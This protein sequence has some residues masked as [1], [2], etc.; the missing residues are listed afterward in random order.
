MQAA[1]RKTFTTDT[2]IQCLDKKSRQRIYVRHGGIGEGWERRGG[3]NRG[4]KGKALGLEIIERKLYFYPTSLKVALT[5]CYKHTTIWSSWRE[6]LVCALPDLY[7]V[8]K[9]LG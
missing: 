1:A 6:Q 9:I 8:E 3:G 5:A 7:T 4:G 2:S